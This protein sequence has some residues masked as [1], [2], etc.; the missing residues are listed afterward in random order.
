MSSEITKINH[1]VSLGDYTP[2]QIKLIQTTVAKGATPDEFALF[3]YRCKI[4]GL[5]PLKPGQ[6]HFIK[7][8]GGPGSIVV[9]IDGMRARAA[10]TGK[11]DGTNR[12]A[13]LNEKGELIGAWAEVSR[14]DW[15]HPAREEVRFAEYSTGKAGW[16]K[17]PETMIK[18]CAEAA[19]LRMAFP[20]ELGGIYAEEEIQKEKATPDSVA[21]IKMLATALERTEEQLADYLS[22]LHKRHIEKPEDLSSEEAERTL[23]TLNQMLATKIQKTNEASNEV[24]S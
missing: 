11:H 4:M 7:Y 3:M 17:M 12:G 19:A 10:R 5:D 21:E 18:K 14:K 24:V 23:V 8:G 16:A 1:S 15:R 2:E 9:G 20:D 22:R 13:I 6:I